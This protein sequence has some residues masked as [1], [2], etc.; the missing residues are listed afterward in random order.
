MGR[1]PFS[2][3]PTISSARPLNEILTGKRW[4]P[5]GPVIS[6]LVEDQRFELCSPPCKDSALPAELIPRENGWH[7]RART[8]TPPLNRRM[9]YH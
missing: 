7:G 2:P 4:A 8:Y 1:A 6:N 3:L 9:L 5:A